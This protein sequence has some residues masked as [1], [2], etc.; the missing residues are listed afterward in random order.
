MIYPERQKSPIEQM[1]ARKA[2]RDI[3][4][5]AYGVYPWKFIHDF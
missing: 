1:A 3:G 2:E 5:A 4:K